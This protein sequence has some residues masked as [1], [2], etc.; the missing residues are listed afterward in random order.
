MNCY[1]RTESGRGNWCRNPFVNQVNVDAMNATV[2][3]ERARI[4]RNPLLARIETP[5]FFSMRWCSRFP[6]FPAC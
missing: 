4:S 1:T 2:N 3:E 5:P 6:S